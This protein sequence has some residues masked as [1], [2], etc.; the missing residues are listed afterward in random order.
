MRARI[1]H[2]V[3]VQFPLHS[4]YPGH[5]LG[6]LLGEP[7]ILLR[8]LRAL[9]RGPWPVV[10]APGM[11]GRW[12]WKAKRRG[13][14][15]NLKRVMIGSIH[16]IIRSAC[17]CAVR[18][19]APGRSSVAGRRALGKRALFRFLVAS[20]QRD[21]AW[22][23]DVGC[24]TATGRRAAS[25]PRAVA[26]M[27]ARTVDGARRAPAITSG[28]ATNRA[29]ARIRPPPRSRSPPAVPGG[30]HNVRTEPAGFEVPHECDD[31]SLTVRGTVC[32]G[33]PLAPHA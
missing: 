13:R 4:D 26:S 7:L 18:R 24:V 27:D 8:Q 11:T 33:V 2:H 23:A 17:L 3:L 14:G 12:S 29:N 10:G 20:Y 16:F 30:C 25:P 6:V 21:H 32:F 1:R 28:W 15:A 31:P 22:R 9:R 5:K 19:G